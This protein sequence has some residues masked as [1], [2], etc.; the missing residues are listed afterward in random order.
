MERAELLDFLQTRKGKLDGVCVSG[1]EPTLQADLPE[2]LWEIRRLGFSVK[3]DTN[4]TAPKLLQE[5]L[6]Q[7]LVDY[8]AMDVKNSP[9]KYTE[10]C[11]GVPCLEQVERSVSLLMSSGLA[12]EF[13]TTVC[14]PLHSSEEIKQIGAWLQGASC[15]VLQQFVD[16]GELLG[17]GLRPLSRLQMEE[18]RQSVLPYIPNTQIRG[19]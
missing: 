15:Y 5:I 11:G 14:A 7:G 4:G 17:K 9:M 1:G 18:L 8:V 10:T 12:Y 19:V 13:R 2:L 3:L 16:S 6:Q